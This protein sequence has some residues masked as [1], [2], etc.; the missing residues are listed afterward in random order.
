[1][2]ALKP[3]LVSLLLAIGSAIPGAAQDYNPL[4]VPSDPNGA[5]AC[6]FRGQQALD[7]NNLYICTTPGSATTAVWTSAGRP[8][9][10][11]EVSTFAA[12]GTLNCPAVAGATCLVTDSGSCTSDT[13]GT[14]AYC[15]YDGSAWRLIETMD[16][17]R[18]CAHGHVAAA[19]TD[20]NCINTS[21][22][23][24]LLNDCGAE[25]GWTTIHNAQGDAFDELRIT[26]GDATGL[27]ASPTDDI[28]F[29]VFVCAEGE[30]P[31]APLGVC[32][33]VG[34]LDND[35]ILAQ[36]SGAAASNP[37]VAFEA[38]TTSITDDLAI[39]VI[40]YDE[41]TDGGVVF[42]PDAVLEVCWYETRF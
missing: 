3:I 16:R 4:I 34:A 14:N 7:G 29:T 17:H 1:M 28:T 36:I 22:G 38:L 35:E 6:S 33:T 5:H 31:T 23:T 26:F 39:V 13:S 21:A 15:Q 42:N 11:D 24:G 41:T 40:H 20:E 18:V 25:A 12:L 9:S 30:D 2:A 27:E 19:P 10:Q 37:Q 8:S 32:T